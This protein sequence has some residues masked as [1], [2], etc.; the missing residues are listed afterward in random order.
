MQEAVL[1]DEHDP[2]LVPHVLVYLQHAVV[3]GRAD[4]AGNRRVVFPALRVRQH[5]P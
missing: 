1:I 3:D 4:Q 5:R 2:G